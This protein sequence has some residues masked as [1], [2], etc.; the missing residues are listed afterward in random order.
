MQTYTRFFYFTITQLFG[1]GVHLGA[2]VT[3]RHTNMVRYIL[4]I[5]SLT[6][7]DI[8]NLRYTLPFLKLSFNFLHNIIAK[9][10]LL[11]VV[12]DNIEFSQHLRDN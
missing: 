9:R 11:L 6:S 4:T 7:F 3:K 10:G 1:N 2:H 12:N 5:K 8:I